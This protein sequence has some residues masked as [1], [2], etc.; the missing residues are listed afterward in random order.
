L[1]F[2]LFAKEEGM[3]E[4]KTAK[5]GGWIVATGALAL[6][7]VVAI[8]GAPRAESRPPETANTSISATANPEGVVARA[9]TDTLDLQLD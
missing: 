5:W 9:E 2:L 7:G 8:S 3:N 1:P 6:A 4:K